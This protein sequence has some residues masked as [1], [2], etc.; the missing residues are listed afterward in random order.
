MDDNKTNEF[1]VFTKK[2]WI[3][4]G[5]IAL[6]AILLLLFKAT[7]S[8]LLLIFAGVLVAV[9]F[10]GL[11]SLI[12]S[13]THWGEGVCVAISII[14]SFSILIALIWLIGSKVQ[15]QFEALSNALPSTISKAEASLRQTPIGEKIVEQISSPKAATKAKAVL[16]TFFSSTFGVFGDIYVVLFV[17][18]FFTISPKTY[19]SGIVKLVPKNGRSKAKEVLTEA[20]ENLKKWLKGKIF[21]MVVVF[22]L[23]SIGLLIIGSPLWLVLAIIAGFLNFIPNFGP[24]IAMV[25][26]VLLGLLQ[27]P[28]TAAIIAALYIVIQV[29]ESNFIT[30]MVQQK[31]LSI[32]PALIIIAQ[33]LIAPLSGGWGLVLA[34]PILVLIMV[35]VQQLY[36]KPQENS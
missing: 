12:Q 21:A 24:L 9:F 5:I 19:T 20:G 34:T 35:L 10:R 29:V 14:G 1:K 22:I 15:S 8:V 13:K 17:G 36:I 2:V 26:A 32:P 27:G 18:I 4:T 28:V 33:L 11:S 23:T 30:P 25:P 3:A 31:L 16:S 7:F 6:T